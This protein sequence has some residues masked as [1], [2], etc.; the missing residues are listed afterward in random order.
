MW[1][2]HFD[3]K[4]RVYSSARASYYTEHRMLSTPDKMVD[5]YNSQYYDPPS[6]DF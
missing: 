1:T 4:E 3:D 5:S 6:Q 2:A